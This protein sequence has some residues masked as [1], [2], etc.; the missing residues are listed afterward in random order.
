M[1]DGNVFNK[2]CEGGQTNCFD[3]CNVADWP[4][5]RLTDDSQPF[6]TLEIRSKVSE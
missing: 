1:A 3:M 6:S 5:E 2:L 4:K